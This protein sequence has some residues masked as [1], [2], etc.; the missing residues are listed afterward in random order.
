LCQT[1]P[2]LVFAFEEEKTVTGN[3]TRKGRGPPK[4]FVSNLE[5]IL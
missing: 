3:A 2:R 1:C 5:L 4:P